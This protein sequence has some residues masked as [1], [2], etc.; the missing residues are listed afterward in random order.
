MEYI[1]LPHTDLVLSRIGFGCEPLGA[2][3]WG[4][5]DEPKAVAAVQKAL[6]IGINLFDTADVYG[7]GRSERFLST[8]LGRHRH[9]VIIASKF[10]INWRANSE[11]GRAHTFFDSSPRR[12]IE[13]LEMSL[14]RLRIDCLA[15]Y[16]VHWPDPNTPIAETLEALLQCRD[17]GKVRYIG[18]SNFSVQLI[19]QSIQKLRLAAIELP[20]NALTRQAELDLL[21]YCHAHEIGV[22]AYSPLSQGLLT[23][24]YGPEARFGN[25]DR[26]HRLPHFQ[27]S[28]L[29]ANLQVVERVKTIGQR[30]GKSPSQVAIRWVLNHPAIAGAIAGAKSP[31]QIQDSAGAVGWC[32]SQADCEYIVNGTPSL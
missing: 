1:R 7:L 4:E 16:F 13:A 21:P 25:N 11:T 30:Y 9:D 32:L 14:R 6:D 17:A 3:D 2:T 29:V 15:L 20:Y 19:E 8:A 23:G 28:N 18:V 22:F 31:E 10:G 26:R 24:K 12:V 27:G 5:F